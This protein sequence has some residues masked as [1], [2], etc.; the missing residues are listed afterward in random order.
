MTGKLQAPDRDAERP[1]QGRLLPN[2]QTYANGRFQSADV[3]TT[4][5]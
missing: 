3:S 4:L 1:I 2:G 5:I